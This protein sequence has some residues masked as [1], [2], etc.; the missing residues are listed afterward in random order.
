MEQVLTAMYVEF[1]KDVPDM[2][3]HVTA[4]LLGMENLVFRVAVWKLS[5]EGYIDGMVPIN[6]GNSDYPAGV[7]LGEAF[8]T[9]KGKGY[10]QRKL[11]IDESEDRQSRLKKIADKAGVLAWDMVKAYA[12]NALDGILRGRKSP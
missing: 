6:D 1:N 2:A 10:V 9:D 5:V 4:R 11:G 7:L 3:E 12:V 8:L